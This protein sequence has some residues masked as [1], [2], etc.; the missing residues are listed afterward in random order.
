[1]QAKKTTAAQLARRGSSGKKT[2]G[3]GNATEKSG[4]ALMHILVA[5]SQQTSRFTLA[6][7]L[8]SWG[9]KVIEAFD[10]AEALEF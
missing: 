1:M 3:I 10:G 9:H 6:A 8:R 7:H 4:N 5:S 2:A